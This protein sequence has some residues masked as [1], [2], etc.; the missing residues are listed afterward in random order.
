MA[1]QLQT[2][3]VFPNA[4]QK[5][6]EDASSAQADDNGWG[7]VVVQPY[8]SVLT[9]NRLITQAD[10]VVRGAH[11]RARAPRWRHR[12][13]SKAKQSGPNHA[14]GTAIQVVLD[15]TAIYRIMTDNLLSTSANP[16]Q[17]N[18]LVVCRLSASAHASDPQKA[19]RDTYSRYAADRH[20]H[21]GVNGHDPVPRLHE[22]RPGGPGGAPHSDAAPALPHQRLH[23][24]LAGRRR[25]RACWRA[26]ARARAT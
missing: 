26:T 21:G 19:D 10:C 1:W 9:L 16:Q 25:S 23:A 24:L 14:R 17:I 5:R 15:N 12:R 2:Y 3:S 11:A 4:S 8:N 7:D 6:S 22:Q 13:G 20:G 18:Q